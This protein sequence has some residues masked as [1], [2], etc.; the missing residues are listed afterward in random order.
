MC[1]YIERWYGEFGC[2]VARAGS[3]V[4]NGLARVRCYQNSILINDD[5]DPLRVSV[6]FNSIRSN[7]VIF[8]PSFLLRLEKLHTFIWMAIHNSCCILFERRSFEMYFISLMC[9]CWFFS[10]LFPLVLNL[11]LY[12]FFGWSLDRFGCS[13]QPMNSIQHRQLIIKCSNKKQKKKQSSFCMVFF[14]PVCVCVC[15]N[16]LICSGQLVL[17][18][19]HSFGFRYS[20]TNMQANF[21][22]TNDIFFLALNFIFA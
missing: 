7:G 3:H 8:F 16:L 15:R 1:A 11:P 18:F 9:A 14:C 5:D 13:A 20:N 12:I 10:L 21:I 17:Y 2:V 6:Q 4:F 22:Y 19:V